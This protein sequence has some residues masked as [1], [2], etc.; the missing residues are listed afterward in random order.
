[1]GEYSVYSY[2]AFGLTMISTTGCRAWFG[3]RWGMICDD[4]DTHLKVV[5]DLPKGKIDHNYA[6]ERL[7]LPK[8]EE[9]PT[10]AV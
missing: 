1:M 4:S 8:V 5:L 2:K 7:G 6:A 3:K 9:Q 10:K